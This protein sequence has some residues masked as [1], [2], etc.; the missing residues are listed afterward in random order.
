MRKKWKKR[1][2]HKHILLISDCNAK[3]NA[4][5]NSAKEN[6][7]SHTRIRIHNTYMYTLISKMYVFCLG[8]CDYECAF[9]RAKPKS[10][11]TFSTI[12]FFYFFFSST[13]TIDWLAF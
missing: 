5:T 1:Y 8:V 4:N 9:V 2:T 3:S 13:D 11:S 10:I 12:A 7:H 6:K